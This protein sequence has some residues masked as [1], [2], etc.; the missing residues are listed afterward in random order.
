M[1]RHTFTRPTDRLAGRQTDR[2]SEIC[3]MKER[4]QK[5]QDERENANVDANAK[6]QKKIE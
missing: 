4:V 6:K 5:K 1:K 3:A 2:Q